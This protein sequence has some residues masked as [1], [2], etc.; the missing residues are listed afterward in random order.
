MYEIGLIKK[1]SAKCFLED[2]SN[3]FIIDEDDVKVIESSDIVF[4][5]DDIS[6]LPNNTFDTKN[7]HNLVESWGYCFENEIPVYGKTFVICCNINKGELKGIHEV[8]NPMNID[9]V[10]LP[11]TQQVKNG[12]II[13]G[14][15]NPIVLSKITSVLMN[16]NIQN[17]SI[18]DM[19]FSAS[20]LANLLE[21]NFRYMNF[22]Y[23]KMI[24]EICEDK[25]E[26]RLFTKFLGLDQVSEDLEMKIKNE[27]LSTIITTKKNP[28]NLPSDIN[29]NLDNNLIYNLNSILDENPNMDIPLIV[30]GVTY[31]KDPSQIN[32]RKVFG[33]LRLLEK[34]YLVNII[35]N[36]E[37]L[38]NKKIISEMSHD[39]VGKIKFYK[40][41]S[42]VDGKPVNL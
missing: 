26:V 23:R 40:K 17:L 22:T 24:E 13:L 16:M 20:E 37:F 12:K 31:F 30:D 2:H 5:F 14:T 27:V 4:F 33:V 35:E 32:P 1:G 39:Y 8:L 38:R 9:I 36:E 34:G 10:Y 42:L 18:T 3:S 19:S 28:I 11:P 21:S 15:L 29:N 7:L 6:L 25:D 41:G